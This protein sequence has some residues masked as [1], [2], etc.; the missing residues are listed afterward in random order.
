MRPFTWLLALSVPTG[1]WAAGINIAADVN[2]DGVVDFARDAPGKAQWSWERG[3]VFLNNNDSDANSGQPDHADDVVNDAAD[4]ADLAPIL[5]QRL[6]SMEPGSV[7]SVGVNPSAAPYIKL[8]AGGSA[9]W[10]PLNSNGSNVLD[11]ALLAV[12]DIELRI[13]ANSYAL[14]AWDGQ[15]DVTATLVPPGGQSVS[16]TVR[17]RVAPWLMLGHSRPATQVY[18]REYI[19]QNDVMRGQLQAILPGI[20]SSLVVSPQSDPYPSNNIWMQ[21]AMEIGY[22]EMPGR[23]MNVVLKS[24]RGPSWPLSNYPKD[25]LLGRDF[26]WFQIGDYRSSFAVGSA[27]DGW[28]DWFGNLEVTPPIIGHPFGRA[29]YGWNPESGQGLDPRIVGMIDAQNLQAP[30]LKL[31]V[32]WLLIQHVDELVCWVPAADGGWRILVPDTR[33]MYQLLDEWVDAG[34]TSQPMMR[35]YEPTESVGAFRN[36]ATDRARNLALQSRRIDP[37]IEAMKSAW[38][39]TEAQVI[40]VPS[41]FYSNG[42]AYVPSMVN[43]LVVNGAILVADPHGPEPD[44]AD[45]MQAH[46]RESLAAAGVEL[47][48]HFLD[49]QRYHRWSGNVHCAT[50][51]RREAYDPGVWASLT[52]EPASSDS[53]NWMLR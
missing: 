26:G 22:S 14:P 5:I 37:V 16:D 39:L 35:L 9:G 40:R 53:E 50:N 1:V 25:E 24:N 4:L 42:G 8:F 28:L 31:D 13:E 34:Y 6:S 23:R 15:V 19:G 43:A 48:V 10:Q 29:Y 7:L 49:D 33:V 3:A 51:A 38:G 11:A 32:G 12:G 52:V 46:F 17:L 45:L 41:A 36:D 21:D 27:P 20:G 2:R 47:A 18:L 44:G 30:A